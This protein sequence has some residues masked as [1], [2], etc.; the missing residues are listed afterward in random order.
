[1]NIPR[2]KWSTALICLGAFLFF[3]VLAFP[4]QNLKGYI[5]GQIHRNTGILIVADEIYLSLFGWP[6]LGVRNVTVSLPVGRE[7]IEVTAEKMIFRVGLGS[8]F[9]PAPSISMSLDGL[10]EGGD[11]YVSVTRGGSYVDA[12]IE[13]DEVNLAQIQ[14]P[15]L[16][17]PIQ[18]I[19]NAEADVLWNEA[20]LPKSAGE[21]ALSGTQVRVPAILLPGFPIPAMDLGKVDGKIRIRNGTVETRDFALGSPDAGLRGNLNG[22]LRLAATLMQSFLDLT[23]RIQLS[24]AY[25]N[26]PQAAAIVSLLKSYERTP[27][28]YG[29]RWSSTLQGMTSNFMNALPQKATN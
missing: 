22:E 19:I 2:I 28:D 11:L 1:M 24:E 3:L 23:L 20:E 6:G 21:I 29:M 9:P 14:I 18:G 10:K 17:A 4:F 16:P 5:F 25:R 8:L 7:E 13:A 15:G 27:G 26:D 12:S